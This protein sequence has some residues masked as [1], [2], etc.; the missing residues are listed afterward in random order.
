MY[1]DVPIGDYYTS[2]T[3]LAE[4]EEA[5]LPEGYFWHRRP[6]M[7]EEQVPYWLDD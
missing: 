3:R 6:V 1:L 7:A 2:A 4:S 5:P